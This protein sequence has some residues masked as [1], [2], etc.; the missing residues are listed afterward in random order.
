MNTMRLVLPPSC[1]PIKVKIHCCSTQLSVLHGDSWLGL[2]IFRIITYSVA[3]PATGNLTLP[4]AY[5]TSDQPCAS[6]P[7][8]VVP[9]PGTDC[10]G[11]PT[12]APVVT[13]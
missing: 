8:N 2:S 7:F 3:G 10:K 11:V 12:S 9:V 13:I 1:H 4:L 6:R 5:R